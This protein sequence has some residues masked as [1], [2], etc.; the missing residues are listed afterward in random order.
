MCVRKHA[1]ARGV[2]WYAAPGKFVQIRCSEIASEATFGP[3][4]HYSYHRYLYVFAC[5]TLIRIDVHMP[6]SGRC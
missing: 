5:M 6:C 3:N 4:R 1:H 2:W